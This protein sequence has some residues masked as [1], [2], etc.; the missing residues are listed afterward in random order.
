M[1]IIR[2]NKR[3]KCHPKVLKLQWEINFKWTNNL[4]IINRMYIKYS[5]VI[6]QKQWKLSSTIITQSVDAAVFFW[7]GK[8]AWLRRCSD[9][10]EV[11]WNLYASYLSRLKRIFGVRRVSNHGL[12]ERYTTKR[13]FIHCTSRPQQKTLL[14]AIKICP[15]Y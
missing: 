5:K 2:S 12:S 8:V 15:K 1:L 6:K 7:L 14:I 11:P 9:D 4:N 3:V 10:F 13:V